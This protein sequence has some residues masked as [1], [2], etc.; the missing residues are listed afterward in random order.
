MRPI[1]TALWEIDHIHPRKYG[2]GHEDGNLRLAHKL[3]NARRG[4]GSRRGLPVAR[5]RQW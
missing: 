3:C 4:D 1:G 5:V 2:G